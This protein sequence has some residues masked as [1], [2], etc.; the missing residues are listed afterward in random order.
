MSFIPEKFIKGF[1]NCVNFT[2][3]FGIIKISKFVNENYTRAPIS[4]LIIIII[5]I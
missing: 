3:N 5:K 2:Y 4:I 1:L